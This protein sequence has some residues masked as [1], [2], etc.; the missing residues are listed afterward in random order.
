MPQ[1]NDIF[2]S[3]KEAPPEGWDGIL[4]GEE[5]THQEVVEIAQK[6]ADEGNATALYVL[7]TAY[8]F[9]KGVPCDKKQ[10]FECYF[11]A[12]AQGLPHAQYNLGVMYENAEACP[13]SHEK[14][15]LWYEKAARQGFAKA[16]HNLAALWEA[17]LGT[18]K[19]AQKAAFWFEEAAGQGDFRAQYRL[20]LLLLR[21]EAKPSSSA[22]P[23][24]APVPS[25]AEEEAPLQAGLLWLRKAA[26]QSFAPAQYTLGLLLE[27]GIG[28]PSNLQEARRLYEAAAAKG[29]P[30]AL[31]AVERLD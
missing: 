22:A 30:E 20:A 13:Q 6:A 14:A 7:G 15:F 23:S 8:Y 21:G 1:E 24:Q 17:G 18:P 28:Q 2:P 27:K 19:S 16:Q 9:G 5:A 12:A 3:E 31:A 25:S 26:E 4:E 11:K 29:V 10:A